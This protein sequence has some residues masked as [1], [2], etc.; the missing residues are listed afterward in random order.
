MCGIAG[1]VNL[2]GHQVEETK[3]L[4]ERMTHIL[5]HRGPDEEGFFLNNYMA[6]GHRRLAIIDLS[7]GKQPMKDEETGLVIVFNG[8]IYNFL[9]LREELLAKGYRFSTQSDTEVILKAYQAW[10]PD[11]VQRLYGMFAFALWDEKERRL[12]LA[13]DRLGKK[14]LY[15]WTNGPLLAFAS[16]IKSLLV[17]DVPRELEPEALDCYFSFGYIPSPLTIFRAIKKLPPAHA[18]IFSEDGMKEFR[19]WQI[20]FAPQERSLEDSLKEFAPLFEE[21]VRTRLISEVPLGA[22]LSG[23]IDSPLVVAKMQEVLQQ[24]VLTNSIGFDDPR[25]N[26][27]P[28]AR[29]IAAHLG[30]EHREFV[31]KPDVKDILPKLAWHFDEP[32]ADSSAVPTYY[33]CQMARQNVTVALSGDG[34]DES[35]GGY[36]FRYIPHLWESRLRREISQ[37]LRSL[38]FSLLGEIYPR[39]SR[40]PKPLRLKTILKNLAVSDA[41]AFYQDLVWLPPEIRKA[42]YTDQFLRELSGFTPYEVVHP[43]YTQAQHLDPVS[44][45]QYVDLHLYL[46]EDVLVKV[47]RMSMAVAL[48]VR[49]PLLDHRIVEFAASLPLA[50]KLQGQRGKVLLREAVKRY[51]PREIVNRPKQGFSVP[52]AEWL[53]GKLRPLVEDV[54]K[55]QSSVLWNYLDLT[56]VRNIWERHLSGRENHSVFFWA[57]MMFALWEKHYL[58]GGG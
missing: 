11:C 4:L 14:P 16:E 55:D 1:F 56:C 24:P 18:L 30:T 42:I 33:V 51:L 27:L 57:V 19:Y 50:L 52:E 9:S 35:F 49:A 26:E 37:P 28:V 25:L 29:E 17:L 36:T 10:G 7:S 58:C 48:E 39:S 46:P 41:K 21:A 44:R 13:R 31:V 45:C 2:K 54:L 22:F 38:V 5:A 53:R 12:F 23:G 32:L 15:Y 3:P 6:F 34:G 8:E 40:L 47:D 20:N 43:L